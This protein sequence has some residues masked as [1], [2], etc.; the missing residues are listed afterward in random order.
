MSETIYAL[1][2]GALPAGI[3]VIRISGPRAFAAVATLVGELPPPRRASLRTLRRDGEPLDR[4][5]VLVFPGPATATGEDLAELHL[6]GG[7]AVVRAVEAALAALPGLRGAEPGEFTRRALAH[8][9]IDLTE[10]EGLGDL[11]AA[12]TEMQRRTALRAAEGGVRAQIEGWATSALRLSALI[13]AML[14]HGDEEDVAAE[15]DVLDAVARDAD[16]LAVAIEAAI[17]QPPV[18]RVRDGIR[19]V[20]AGSPNAGKSTLLNALAGREAAIVSPLAGTTRD[21][22][23][24]PVMRDGVAYLLTDTAGLNETPADMVEEIGIARA[25]SAI[26][27]ADLVLWL[28]DGPPSV[29]VA[30]VN[31]LLIRPRI[32]EPGRGRPVDAR[33]SVSAA[34]GQGI[35]ALWTMIGGVAATLLPPSD[36]VALNARQRG[37]AGQAASALRRA[38]RERDALLVAEE[39]RTALRAFHRVTGA[40]DVEAMLDTLF[41]RFCIGK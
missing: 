24:V 28:D 40:A 11:L 6:H 27:T 37:L 19:I 3:A 12:E 23:E 20:L 4:A 36:A 15:G 14:D 33:H 8:G 22:I 7:R 18:E 17:A 32:D 21:R 9:R 16:L 38:A 1:S 31:H 10:A 13:E 35:E 2:S 30:A 39:L 29:E 34:T 5:L 25:R 41:G 26:E